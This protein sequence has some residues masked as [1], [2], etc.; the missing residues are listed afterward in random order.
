MRFETVPKSAGLRP[1]DSLNLGGRNSDDKN[2][3]F[4]LKIPH[5]DCLVISVHFTVKIHV[6]V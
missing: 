5:A 3:R 4:I 6:A 1:E 2:L